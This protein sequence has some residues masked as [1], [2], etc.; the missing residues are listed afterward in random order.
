MPFQKDQIP[1]NYKGKPDLTA[2]HLTNLTPEIAYIVGAKVGDGCAWKWKRTYSIGLSVCDKPF[3][4]SFYTALKTVGLNPSF[5]VE[6]E[7]PP[8]HNLWR[9]RARNKIFYEW[10][11]NL[12]IEKIRQITSKS[13]ENTIAFLRG[14]YEAEGTFDPKGFYARYINTNP[15]LLE[16]TKELLASLN[17]RPN[18]RGPYKN[19]LEPNKMIYHL[20]IDWEKDVRTFFKL[21][22]PSIKQMKEKVLTPKQQERVQQ[23][24]KALQLRKKGLS[25]YQISREI[26][27]RPNTVWYWITGKTKPRTLRQAE[28]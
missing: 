9:V 25:T 26:G 20:C 6:K 7:K 11:K 14:F 15:Q 28:L 21:V 5:G 22:N 17:L 19:G 23:H 16:L 27:V 18:L 1:W 8:R 12:T 2:Y 24:Q 13:T 4:E 3:A 10:L